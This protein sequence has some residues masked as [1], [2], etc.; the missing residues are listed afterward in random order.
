MIQGKAHELADEFYSVA[1]EIQRLSHL[2]RSTDIPQ[3]V[4][5]YDKLSQLV[6][7]NGDFVLQS[8]EV[9]NSQLSG[10]FKY[11]RE[12]SKSFLEAQNLRDE[13]KRIYEAR[14]SQLK[15]QKESLF[16]RQ[17]VL[18]WRVDKEHQIAAESN[19]TNPVEAFKYILPDVTRNY[20]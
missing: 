14:S 8:G 17:D 3:S 19:K 11:H 15:K 2:V 1:A 5:L 4:M 10:W 13:S 18:A 16:K 9:L 12:E 6:L 20:L 7:R